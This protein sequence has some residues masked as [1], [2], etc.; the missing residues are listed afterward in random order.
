MK[1]LY[2]RIGFNCECLIIVRF[3]SEH[4]LLHRKV[5]LVYTHMRKPYKDAIIKNAIYVKMQGRIFPY[6]IK[7]TSSMVRSGHVLN[8][9]LCVHAQNVWLHVQT[10]P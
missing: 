8:Q 5:L 9:W 7:T 6:A 3:F 1:T 10:C 4:T 2:H